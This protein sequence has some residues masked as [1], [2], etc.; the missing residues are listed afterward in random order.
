M[1]RFGTNE[2]RTMTQKPSDGQSALTPE[3]LAQLRRE[4][5]EE[6][7][8]AQLH[9]VERTGG[10]ELKDFIEELERAARPNE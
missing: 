2:V 1:D 8:L 7:Y 10:L 9:E 4:F 6:D 3:F 5:K